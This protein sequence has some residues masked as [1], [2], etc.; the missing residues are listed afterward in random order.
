MLASVDPVYIGGALCLA[1]ALMQDAEEVESGEDEEGEGGA[2]GVVGG[3]LSREVG[4]E[5]AEPVFDVLRFIESGLVGFKHDAVVMLRKVCPLL[6][7]G[8]LSITLGMLR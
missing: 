2:L 4:F 8:L 7:T 6:C 3:V 5:A 1:G